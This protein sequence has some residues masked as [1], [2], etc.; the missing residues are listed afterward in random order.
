MSVWRPVHRVL[1]NRRRTR[2]FSFDH[3]AH[4]DVEHRWFGLR[5]MSA[6]AVSL[7]SGRR[8]YWTGSLARNMPSDGTQ[9]MFSRS[10]KRPAT[11]AYAVCTRRLVPGRSSL[12]TVGRNATLAGGRITDRPRGAVGVQAIAR[13]GTSCAESLPRTNSPAASDP[14]KGARAIYTASGCRRRAYRLTLRR[15][16]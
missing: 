7:P 10:G 14:M 11:A 13:T 16:P 3:A 15:H 4:D 12:T 2:W 5:N 6:G 1:A 8:V 9:G